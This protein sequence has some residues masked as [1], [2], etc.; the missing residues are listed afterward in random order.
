MLKSI[1]VLLDRSAR[2]FCYYASA[3][4]PAN[5]EWISAAHLRSIVDYS[6]RHRTTLNCLLGKRPLPAEHD[7]LLAQANHVKLVPAELSDV[8]PDAIAIVDTPREAE[9]LTPLRSRNVILRL[10]KGDLPDLHATVETLLERCG[11]INL[12]L[13]DLDSYADREVEAYRLQLEQVIPLLQARYGAG[14]AVEVSFLSDRMLRH[15]MHNC[16]A[17]VEHLTFAP[18]GQFYLCPGFFQDGAAAVGDLRQGIQ[19]RNPQLY[20]LDHAPICSRCDAFHCKRCVYLNQK[21][22]GEV[23][24]PSA[25]Q[26]VTAHLE[27]NASSRLLASLQH[28]RSFRAMKPFGELTNLDPFTRLVSP[29]RRPPMQV[30]DGYRLVTLPPLERVRPVVQKSKNSP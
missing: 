12:H 26:C 22:T 14:D 9:A 5:E 10:A 20:R 27:R 16:N 11:R 15:A 1:I 6:I 19:I 17:G 24:T 7:E 3:D 13:L 25:Q 30:R 2:S 4:A 18:D 23:N 8:Y 21:T 28:I 29:P